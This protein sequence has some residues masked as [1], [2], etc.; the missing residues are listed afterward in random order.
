MKNN[1][2]IPWFAACCAALSANVPAAGVSHHG[3][4]LL[5]CDPPQFFDETPAKDS[6]VPSFQDFSITASA[7]TDGSTVKAA[8]NNEP[9]AVTIT[10]ER[11]G[12]LL[13]KGSL[14]APLTT[15]RAWLRVTGDSK[16]GCDEL[17]V[18][19]VYMP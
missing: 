12:R 9:V 16:D 10:E 19:N 3:G 1:K 5:S 2:L 13:I 14:K 18:W 4:P 7:N 17:F 8:V 6:K 15:G 11:S